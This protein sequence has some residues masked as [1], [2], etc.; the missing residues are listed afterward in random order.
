MGGR[1]TGAHYLCLKIWS[2][3]ALFTCG[4]LDTLLRDISRTS[5]ELGLWSLDFRV[6]LPHITLE[7]QVLL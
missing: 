2:N 1:H 6:S 5:L 7:T 3:L 4:R